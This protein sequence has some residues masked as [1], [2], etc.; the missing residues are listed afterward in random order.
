MT[1]IFEVENIKCG[2]CMNTIRKGLENLPGVTSAA[3]DNTNGTVTVDFDE[4]TATI[5]AISDKLA[6]M[7]YPLAGENSLVKKAQSYVSCMVGRVTE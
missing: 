7:G 1:H 3:P 2:G 6:S 4:K 5:A